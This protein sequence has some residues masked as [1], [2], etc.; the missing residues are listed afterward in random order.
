MK[1]FRANP[2]PSCDV[3]RMD[4][5]HPTS[6]EAEALS[7]ATRDL[8]SWAQLSPGEAAAFLEETDGA[9]V[10]YPSNTEAI[11]ALTQRVSELRS[12]K[13]KVLAHWEACQPHERR[14]F[15]NALNAINQ[16][17]HTAEE[18]LAQYQTQA[19]AAN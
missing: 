9:P 19:K 4:K 6:A 16:D 7:K 18:L 2:L 14:A 12:Q 17:C 5:S 3:P 1:N 13:A 11:A 10:Q 15:E 8:P